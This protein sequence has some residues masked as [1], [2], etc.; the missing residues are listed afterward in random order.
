M[1]TH[2]LFL[3]LCSIPL[4][5]SAQ[6]GWEQ[7]ADLTGPARYWAVAFAIGDHGYVGTGLHTPGPVYLN[8][9]WRYEPA[10]DTWTAR[11]NSSVLRS[12]GAAIGIG[13]YGFMGMGNN[14]S[15]QG[16]VNDWWR[17]DPTADAWSQRAS[18]PGT[19]RVDV[20]AFSVNGKGYLGGGILTNGTAFFDFYEYD[21]ASD[22]WTPRTS[23]GPNGPRSSTAVFTI[24]ERAYVVAGRT[25]VNGVFSD[26]TFEYDPA[27]D[28][29]TE[30]ADFP[31]G[32][33]L[34]AVGFA[35][36]GK[37]YVGMGTTGTFQ[38][39]LYEYDA[40]NDQWQ[41]VASLQGPERNS[42][43]AFQVG[44]SGYIATGS[45]GTGVGA[46]NDLWR[47]TPDFGTTVEHRELTGGL[48][49][50]PNPATDRLWIQPPAGS[51][52]TANITLLDATGRLVFERNTAG[53]ALQEMDLTG[54]A[55]GTYMV[56]YSCGGLPYTSRVVVH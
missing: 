25:A 33:R 12:R 36:N 7:R 10:T 2:F 46:L 51:S 13:Q 42:P 18:F 22:Q 52:G 39:D 56:R 54:V 40:D 35:V 6:T 15:T 53:G 28:Q 8:D 43:V 49:I 44:T 31:G 11:A 23:L 4:F 27:T 1:R 47:F 21:P 5:S 19:A 55:S 16:P 34:G 38:N 3:L 45:G 29:W 50:F 9:L 30:K 20:V 37:G 48:G 14:A 32:G 24:G 17:Y 26:K 41:A